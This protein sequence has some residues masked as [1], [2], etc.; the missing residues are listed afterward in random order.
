M[1]SNVECPMCGA[2]FEVGDDPSKS[3]DSVLGP[4]IDRCSRRPKRRPD[5]LSE[6][7]NVRAPEDE[8]LRSYGSYFNF[9]MLTVDDVF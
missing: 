9:R 2:V 7:K 6:L 5:S 4:H 8:V 3:P 1:S